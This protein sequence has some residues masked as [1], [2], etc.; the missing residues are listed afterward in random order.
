M[1]ARWRAAEETAEE[2]VRAAEEED[3]RLTR[4]LQDEAEAAV[5]VEEAEA[6]AGPRTLARG[7]R[8]VPEHRCASKRAQEHSSAS[9]PWRPRRS[10]W[11]LA[12]AEPG[13]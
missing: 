3:R 10:A 13:Q 9:R 8:E 4:R 6:L 1:W 12:R 11:E 2:E 7:G 5:Q